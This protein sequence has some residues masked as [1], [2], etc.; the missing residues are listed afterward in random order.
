MLDLYK[1]SSLR[2]RVLAVLSERTQSFINNGSTTGALMSSSIRRNPLQLFISHCRWCVSTLMRPSHVTLLVPRAANF[3]GGAQN[4]TVPGRQPP[5]LRP[6]LTTGAING[7]KSPTRGCP[8]DEKRGKLHGSHGKGGQCSALAVGSTPRYAQ[9]T[10]LM[11]LVY[12]AGHEEG[13][14]GHRGGGDWWVYGLPKHS[15]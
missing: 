3:S 15:T 6:G 12:G 14:A 11:D 10:S 8:V 4:L 13:G 1:P 5:F 2:L 7:L 9:M